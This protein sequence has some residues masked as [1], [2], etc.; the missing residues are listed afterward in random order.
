MKPLARLI[1]ADTLVPCGDGRPRRYVNLDYAASTPVMAAVW[2]A[3][4]AFVPWYSS[5]HRGSGQKSQL[6]TAAFED[7]RHTVAGFVGAGAADAVIFVRNTTEAINVLSAALPAGTRVLASAVEHHS[8]LLPWRR[9]DVRLLPAAGSADELVD[10]CERTLRSARPRIDLVAVTG[11]SNV[12][13]EVWPV[14]EL[15]AIAHAHGARLFVDAAQLAPH[16]RIKMAATGID[17]LALS[18]HKLYA[19][20]GAGALVGD[21]GW[22]GAREPLLQGGGA[23]ELVTA[24]DVIWADA[25]QRHEAG[26][27]NVVGAVAL[28][29]ACRALLDLGMDAVAAHERA[30]SAR[31][32]SALPDVPGLRR[33]ML[34]PD[35]ADRVAV[36]TFTLDG[37]R[38]PLLAAILSA[39]HAIGVRHGCFCAHPLMTRL[40]RVPDDELARL[41]RELRAGRHPA[42]PG[43]VRASLGLGT[44]GDDIDRLIGAL[45]EIATTGPRSRYRHS[46]RLDEYQPEPRATRAPAPERAHAPSSVHA[47]TDPDPC[48]AGAPDR[49]RRTPRSVHS[50]DRQEHTM[51]LAPDIEPTDAPEPPLPPPAPTP[52][53]LCRHYFKNYVDLFQ[54]LV[55]RVYMAGNVDSPIHV[56]PGMTVGSALE[57]TEQ[58]AA[59]ALAVDDGENLLLG[60]IRTMLDDSEVAAADVEELMDRLQEILTGPST[61]AEKADAIESAL[62][63]TDLTDGQVDQ[64][65]GA[66]RSVGQVIS[67]ALAFTFPAL[68][69]YRIDLGADQY[70][71]IDGPYTAVVPEDPD[72]LLS[73]VSS[74][75]DDRLELRI[76]LDSFEIAPEA[77]FRLMGVLG[78]MV[79]SLLDGAMDKIGTVRVDGI[80]LTLELQDE[81][82]FPDVAYT[83]APG[84]TVMRADWTVATSRVNVDEV[85][86]DLENDMSSTLAALLFCATTVGNLEEDGEELI[87]KVINASGDIAGV[88]AIVNAYVMPIARRLIPVGHA[89]SRVRYGAP[90]EVEGAVSYQQFGGL[91]TVYSTRSVGIMNPKP[92]SPGKP[93]GS[94]DDFDDLPDRDDLPDL[95]GVQTWQWPTR[96]AG[97]PRPRLDLADAG[98]RATAVELLAAV[99]SLTARSKAIAALDVEGFSARAISVLKPGDVDPAQSRVAGRPVGAGTLALLRRG[100]EGTEYLF[101]AGGF[102]G[103]AHHVRREL[104]HAM[105]IVADTP[106][107]DDAEED[108]IDQVVVPDLD[109]GIWS[110]DHAAESPLSKSRG[111]GSDP[112]WVGLSTN[113]VL[114]TRLYR[115]LQAQGVLTGASVAH[116]ESLGHIAYEIRGCTDIAAD[117]TG[118]ATAGPIAGLGVPGPPAVVMAGLVVAV[119]D[120]LKPYVVDLR[121]LLRPVIYSRG[122]LP[123]EAV[124]AVFD[125]HDCLETMTG[126]AF[127]DATWAQQV[128][129]RD[130]VFLTAD[131]QAA[132]NI[133][134]LRVVEQAGG[135]PAGTTVHD[136]VRAAVTHWFPQLPEL[137]ILYNSFRSLGGETRDFEAED[138]W[139]S[140]YRRCPFR[141]FTGVQLG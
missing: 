97:T 95:G 115:K 42:L 37:Y 126:G 6:S 83:W 100:A 81:L 64:A 73:C 132:A 121:L 122:C 68:S 127:P 124:T 41:A 78:G 84:H 51:T 102:P 119:G 86:L 108:P 8:N 15:A 114:A 87:R 90:F 116:D 31:L 133:R 123:D 33:L 130:F 14:A 39:E 9:H 111:S 45:H 67:D 5:V 23:I 10:A 62:S 60:L 140:I 44:T 129:Y 38:H 65:A 137:P 29:A 32:W 128:A 52:L 47:A 72:Q 49:P 93:G 103:R 88:A 2:E 1:G 13:G 7:A 92:A 40:L 94:S 30:L 46:P 71:L 112:G 18:G 48:Q 117:F 21:T 113:C 96:T 11:A 105:R 4:A 36:A 106:P 104:Q 26:S 141:D 69:N 118:G 82:A 135:E 131:V 24:D 136:Q 77:T 16:R 98:A 63:L 120:D 61:F 35:E 28:A 66:F 25:P 74:E 76:A 54:D 107:T 19:P 138:G 34:W 59:A 85:S 17:F 79:Q 101:R 12:T 27:P 55:R 75:G 91:K 56:R 50:P 89:L 53:V 58:Q 43:A 134:L 109:P 139:L 110:M 80:T 57:V 70:L 20:F 125:A 99:R 22:L 3:V